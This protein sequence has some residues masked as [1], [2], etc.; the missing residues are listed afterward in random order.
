MTLGI[1]GP[2]GTGF[3]GTSNNWPRHMKV[4][5]IMRIK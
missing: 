5:W 1:N 4:I 3:D 2:S